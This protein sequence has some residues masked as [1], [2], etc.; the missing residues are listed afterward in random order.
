LKRLRERGLLTYRWIPD[1]T[2]RLL[3]L[4]CAAGH[5]TYYFSKKAQYTY[6]LD[7]NTEAI[8]AAKK[9]YP[10]IEFLP[11]SSGR[12]PF[13]DR[14][15]DVVTFIEVLEHLPPEEEFPAIKEIYRVLKPGGVMILSVPHRG[16]FYFL[17][18]LD[19][20]FKFYRFIKWLTGT[21]RFDRIKTGCYGGLKGHKH[22]RLQEIL[23]LIEWG[24][25]IKKIN[26]NSLILHPL[27]TWTY[28]LLKK[29][30]WKIK[31]VTQLLEAVSD[32]DFKHE[33][34][35]L[36]YNLHLLAVKKELEHG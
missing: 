30:N 36:A 33:F 18:P 6:G 11:G 17:D 2:G 34:G 10:G 7:C 20:R 31:L 5:D 28:L 4:G 3:D 35:P 29:L 19:F 9:N 27:S 32:F 12:L 16:W 23:G 14:Y 22:Y 13:P 8:A 21:K 15:F 25:S 24:F 26:R 1:G